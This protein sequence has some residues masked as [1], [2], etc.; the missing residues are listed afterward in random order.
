VAV[1]QDL[2]GGV[3]I[4]IVGSGPSGFYA[5]AAALAESSRSFSVDVIDRLPVPYGLVRGGVAPDHQKI[6][7]VIRAYEKTSA[8][9]RFRFFGNFCVG[10]DAAPAEL[11][12][13]YD[14]VVY[15]VGAES[16]NR[17]GIPGE[18]LVGSH[19]ATAFVGWYNA[20]PDHQGHHFDLGVPGAAVVGV[21]NVSMDVARILAC[22][23][24]HLAATDITDTALHALAAAGVRDVWILGRRGPV[25]AAF[26][27]A[28]LKE[29]AELPGVDLR[30]L[31]DE[32]V[33]DPTSAAELAAGG[34]ANARKN[35]EFLA[36]RAQVPPIANARVR[37]HLRLRVSPVE[38]RGSGCVN[39]L[40]IERNR[41]VPDGRGSVRAE[42]TGEREILPVGLVFRAVGYRGTA[43]PGVPFD[44]RRGIVHNREGRV[45]G[46]DGEIVP[47]TY[48]V[49]WAKRGPSG[50]IGTNRADSKDTVEKLVEDLAGVPPAGHPDPLPWL[51]ERQPAL[52]DWADWKRLDSDEV[53]TGAARGKVRHKHADVAS[54]LRRMAELRPG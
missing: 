19:S 44:E 33:L 50:L 2:D 37:V 9:P 13:H 6:K 1:S 26:T 49:G 53:A 40:V 43:I 27:T 41:L 35:V 24:D 29:L 8:D 52:V 15:A 23:A 14:A 7:T 17:L 28:E 51:R 21:G 22:G 47:R 36:A 34:D 25:Q 30:V 5:A 16:A 42:G 12:A 32:V 18:D 38:M 11:L 48:V 20:H 46:L 54:M 39:G 45:V 31:P 4:A 3:R 10:R